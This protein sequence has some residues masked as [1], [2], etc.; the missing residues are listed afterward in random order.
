VL[1]G[2]DVERPSIIGTA[3]KISDGDTLWICDETACHKIR[4]CGIDAPELRNEGGPEA[5][6][7]LLELVTDKTVRCTQSVT[8]PSVM[9]ALA[10]PTV[11]G[12]WHSVSS[13]VSTL[14][15]N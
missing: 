15:T 14:P 8:E 12:S 11:T 3:C 13:M 4:L 9:I 1:I 5:R 7:E 6:G 10:R 2:L